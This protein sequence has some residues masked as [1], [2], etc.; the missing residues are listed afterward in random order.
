MP[1]P[2]KPD[3]PTRKLIV[4]GVD[5]ETIFLLRD[6]ASFCL[7]PSEADI[8]G[9][10]EFNRLPKSEQDAAIAYALKGMV[11]DA[12]IRKYSEIGYRMGKS[13]YREQQ[14]RSNEYWENNC[15]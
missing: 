12:Y 13:Q 3:P 1:R 9:I 2:K 10:E 14:V 4:D 6:F 7:P 15:E 8:S 5:S 11:K